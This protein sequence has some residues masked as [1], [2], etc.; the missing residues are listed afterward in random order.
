M[1][2]EQIN[3]CLELKRIPLTR[4]ML[5]DHYQLAIGM[6]AIGG[7]GLNLY[8]WNDLISGENFFLVLAILFII[9]ALY[10]FLYLG[11]KQLKLKKLQIHF[12]DNSSAYFKAK[13]V[14]SFYKWD[15]LEENGTNYIKALRKDSIFG[16]QSPWKGRAIS[17]FIKQGYIYMISMYHPSTQS[18][19]LTANKRNIILF[20]RKIN[21][22]TLNNKCTSTD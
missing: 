13:G 5:F 8:L 10:I 9:P 14:F 15:I 6:I 4:K 1:T 18:D 22:F 21:E 16:Y 17:V 20:E 12:E 11:R 2:P 3:R 19:F 7:G